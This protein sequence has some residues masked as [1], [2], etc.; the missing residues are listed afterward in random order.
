MYQR[1]P[2]YNILKEVFPIQ[3]WDALIIVVAIIIIDK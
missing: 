1:R 2:Y 3:C